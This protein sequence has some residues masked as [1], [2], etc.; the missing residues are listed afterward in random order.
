MAWI[1][2]SDRES[3]AFS[4]GGIGPACRQ[5]PPDPDAILARGSILI[6]TRLSPDGRPQT[7][8]SCSKATPWPATFSVQAIPGGGVAVVAG[9]P[10]RDLFHTALSDASVGR[11]DVLRIT[12]SWDAPARRGRLV[13]ERPESG[14]VS[15]TE[16][17]A[18]PPLPVAL[19]RAMAR[20]TT[21]RS[22]D[23]DVIYF[24][25]SDTVEPVGPMPAMTDATPVDTA[26][27]PMPLRCLRRGDVVQ[28]AHSGLQPVLDVPSR[29][30]PARGSF[31]PVRLRAPYFGL[32]ED[33]V[34]APEQRLLLSGSDVEY[35]FGREGVLVA[36]RHLANGS[37]ALYE[38]DRLLVRYAQPLLPGHET[39]H[40]AGA[41][42]ESLY[43]GRLRRKP[44]QLEASLLHDYG[45]ARLPEHA[46]AAYRLLKPYEAITLV[47]MRAA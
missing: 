1:G 10:G 28:T 6:E 13:L 45:R 2:L 11:A 30:V 16:T 37:A 47:E 8:L 35:L 12:Y 32:A 36:A 3:S 42:L 39:L 17:M 33:I 41:S 4:L 43:I 46:H 25:I 20:P 38:E 22:V 18:P 9:Q 26:Q 27:G 5:A 21:L 31:Q 29:E 7:L 40:C 34:V 44:A 14:Y 15:L 24:A 23:V 19:L